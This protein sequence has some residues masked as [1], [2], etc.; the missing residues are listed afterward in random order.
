MDDRTWIEV[1]M[2][3]T[4]SLLRKRLEELN[5]TDISR[6]DCDDIHEIHEIYKVF[7]TISMLRKA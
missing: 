4:T 5:N 1:E 7:H 6:L 3:E 2:D